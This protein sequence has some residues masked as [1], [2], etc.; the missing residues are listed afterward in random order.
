MIANSFKSMVEQRF[1]VAAVVDQWG[2][3]LVND[4]IVVWKFIRWDEV[5]PADFGPVN[6]QFFR[7]NI[8]QALDDEHTML[9]PRAAIG[10]DDSF[11]GEDRGELAIIVLDV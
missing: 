10:C 2:K 6:I 5:A 4:F 9:P 11:V 3:I 8:Q 1:V 7:G